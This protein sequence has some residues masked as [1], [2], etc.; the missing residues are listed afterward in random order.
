M[1]R[2]KVPRRSP[3]P[4]GAVGGGKCEEHL[5]G[6]S[7]GP[8]W[9]GGP[10]PRPRPTYVVIRGDSGGKPTLSP[11]P[12][13]L[14][15]GAYSPSA[16]KPM[17]RSVARG[18]FRVAWAA[19][20]PTYAPAG[21]GSSS[22]IDETP[23]A[24]P[25]LAPWT[26]DVPGTPPPVEADA[27]PI[28]SALQASD[29]WPEQGP[30]AVEPPSVDLDLSW[31]TDE[32]RP[33]PEEPPRASLPAPPSDRMLSIAPRTPTTEAWHRGPHHPPRVIAIWP[34]LP[35]LGALE[36]DLEE[37]EEE[38]E[39]PPEPAP[40]PPPS[41]PWSGSAPPESEGAAPAPI[42]LGPGPR[43]QPLPSQGGTTA[44]PPT[45]SN[46]TLVGLLARMWLMRSAAEGKGTAALPAE[47]SAPPPQ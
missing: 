29:E 38:S 32:T 33:L 6:P 46:R 43:G 8:R 30:T 45:A 25:A 40:Q 1:D 3:V 28:S 17:V 42:P 4:S 39:P 15:G 9:S 41:R 5:P 23:P 26:R 21:E 10:P 7:T 24:G 47:R 31:P 18:Q 27:I 12:T 16:G 36:P 20:E 22:G 37:E 44:E 14:N 2:L 13:V 19:A 11:T 34:E 35:P